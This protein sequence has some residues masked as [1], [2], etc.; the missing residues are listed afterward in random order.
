MTIIP[1]FLVHSKEEFQEKLERVKGVVSHIHVDVM[2]GIF[3]PNTTWADPAIIDQCIPEGMTYEA[4]CMVVDP[5][6]V[7]SRWGNVRALSRFIFHTET[8]H[9]VHE[10]LHCVRPLKKEVW[11]ACNPETSIE[12]VQKTTRFFDGMLVMGVHPGFSGQQLEESVIEKIRLL[13]EHHPK[14]CLSVDGG[15]NE[16]TA[17]VLRE[18]GANVL[19]AASALFQEKDIASAIRKLQ[20]A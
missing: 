9:H 5:L 18:A 16:T 13:R 3:V 19:V 11:L 12:K 8:I 17:P 4:H 20:R 2:D 1:A 10:L 7:C 14:L 15:V 6:R